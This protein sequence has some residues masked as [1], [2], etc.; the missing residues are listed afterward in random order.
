MARWALVSPP[1]VCDCVPAV[2]VASLTLPAFFDDDSEDDSPEIA[3]YGEVVDLFAPGFFIVGAA[4]STTPGVRNAL[5]AYIF[6]WSAPAAYVAGAAALVLEVRACEPYQSTVAVP[7]VVE[8][9][10]PRYDRALL[11]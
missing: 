1:T 9:L 2:I 6:S 7:V 10:A 11:S 5:S 4:S 8:W 3:N